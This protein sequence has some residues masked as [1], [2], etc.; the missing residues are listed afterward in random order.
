MF[1]VTWFDYIFFVIVGRTIV[2]IVSF[3]LFILFISAAWCGLAEGWKEYRGSNWVK[4]VNPV[5]KV[6]A[7]LWTAFREFNRCVSKVI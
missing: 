7:C 1:E 2:A 5:T 3:M 6:M 4:D